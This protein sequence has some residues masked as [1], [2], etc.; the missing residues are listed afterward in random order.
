MNP[1]N[2]FGYNN[3]GVFY[4]HINEFEKALLDFNKAI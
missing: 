3:R 1:S 4:K 2:S